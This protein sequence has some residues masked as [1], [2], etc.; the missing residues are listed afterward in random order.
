MT[1]P[2]DDG[3]ASDAGRWSR[4][5]EWP[6]SPWTTWVAAGFVLFSLFALLIGPLLL[7]ARTQSLRSAVVAPGDAARGEINE[8]RQ[9]FTAGE[10]TL[11]SEPGVGSTF[12]LWLPAEPSGQ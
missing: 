7:N 3:P 9:A 11:D 1:A 6:K 5:L 12:T 4:P 10:V 8:V 2:L